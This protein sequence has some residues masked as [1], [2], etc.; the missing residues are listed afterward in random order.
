MS[1]TYTVERSRVVD[2]PADRVYQLVADFE[3]W[4]RWSPW[5]DVDPAMQRTFSGSESGT[6]AVYSWSGNRRAGQGRMQII[7]AVQP[8]RVVIH[9][10][11]EKPWRARNETRFLIEPDGSGSHVTWSMTGKKTLMTK[12]MGVFRSMDA[13]LGPDFER[14]LAQLKAAAER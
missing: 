5:E 12:A 10:A 6:G 9:L 7:E 8:S 4:T 1:S 11:F 3:Q 14:G 13:M 2:A